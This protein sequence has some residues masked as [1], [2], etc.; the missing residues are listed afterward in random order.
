M[1]TPLSGAMAVVAA[2]TLPLASASPAS[3]S[4]S[5]VRCAP[6]RTDEHHS[7]GLD[8]WNPSYTRPV[9]RVDAVMVFLRF[10]DSTPEL[11]TSQIADDHI[12]DTR[13]F[14]HTASY[15]K[16][17]YNLV[18]VDGFVTMPAPSTAYRIARDWADEPRRRYL[19]DA[20]AAA[21]RTVDFRDFDAVFLVA[22]PHAPGVD[23]D[24]TKVVNL[25]RPIV[26]DGVPLSH[27]GTIFEA[28][29][30]DPHVFAHETAHVFDLPDLY[31]RPDSN[32]PGR[33][34]ND[35]VGDWDLMGDQKG[36]APDPFAWHKWK[37][38]W[39]T[40]AQVV[41]L[42]RPGSVRARL[43]PVEVRGGTKL[44]VVQLDRHTAYAVEVRAR[45]G[46]DLRTC[47]EG[48]LVYRVRSDVR[49]GSGPVRVMDAHPRRAACPDTAVHP[50]LAD[51]PFTRG[52]EFRDRTTGTVIRVLDRDR[53]GN[54]V[55]QAERTRDAWTRR[56]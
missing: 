40:P 54:Y 10:P 33:D 55:V 38:G 29:P 39:L 31:R 18:P 14:F 50:P 47:A 23:P 30:P 52:E 6:V 25:A 48:A 41:C 24:A 56:G 13:R 1:R 4:G 51:A 21:D 49:S 17:D 27:I 9:G 15:G 36:L 35:Q 34:W 11:T 42:D 53:R 32:A 46:N 22:D 20:L 26:A 3:P 2:L 7:E 37:L 44:L 12:P 19:A 8:T 16:L 5:A 45:R 43:S 28:H